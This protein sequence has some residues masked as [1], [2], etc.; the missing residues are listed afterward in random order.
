VT[1]LKHL[2]DALA[3]GTPPIAWVDRA[4]MPYLQLPA[5]LKG[6]LGHLV[7]IAGQT[8][9]SFLIDDLASDPFRATAEDLADA[10]ARIA[11]YKNR[12]L[13]PTPLAP[14]DLPASILAGLRDC[15]A[16]LL[17]KSDSFSL[18]TFHKWAKMLTDKKNKKGWPVLFADPSGLYGLLQSVFEGI[19]LTDAGGGGL[20]SLY[21]AF[22]D[23]AAPLVGLPALREV[24]DRYRSLAARWTALAEAALPDRVTEFRQ[25]KALL[26]RKQDRLLA[27]GEAAVEGVRSTTAE[28]QA[29]HAQLNRAFPLDS[30]QTQVLFADLSDRLHALYAAEVDTARALAEVIA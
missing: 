23:E 3:A 18:P 30:L 21:A 19:E 17:G 15:A 5:V 28:I 26:R 4:H 25:A 29:L 9:G 2:H 12:L 16:N 11:S 13:I 10:R 24:A 6:H 27:E 7:A 20:R 14:P 22:L 8:G 1:A